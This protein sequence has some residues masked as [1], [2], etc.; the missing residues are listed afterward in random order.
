MQTIN[1]VLSFVNA[2]AEKMDHDATYALD[3][4]RKECDYND[5]LLQGI[6]FVI[7]S[8]HPRHADWLSNSITGVH[9]PTI[10]DKSNEYEVEFKVRR[11]LTEERLKTISAM[12][13][14]GKLNDAVKETL[15][16]IAVL[17]EFSVMLTDGSCSLQRRFDEHQTSISSAMKTT[18]SYLNNLNMSIIADDQDRILN[19]MTEFK[20][21]V[22]TLEGLVQEILI[23]KF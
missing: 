12:V 5:E 2:Y 20:K 17:L 4:L 13:H 11:A 19:T 21:S 15:T 8:V 22:E 3:A 10:F 23:T 18:R 1:N 7:A 16:T 6:L 14:T 9:V